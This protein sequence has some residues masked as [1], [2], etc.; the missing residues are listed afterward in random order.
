MESK[1]GIK[2]R[3]NLWRMGAGLALGAV[4]LFLALRFGQ[5]ED[6]I[7]K[8]KR[9]SRY[10]F[11]GFAPRIGKEAPTDERLAEWAKQSGLAK[12]ALQTLGPKSIPLLGHWLESTHS[13]Y[14]AK[15]A[16]VTRRLGIHWPALQ[17]D[18]RSIALGA[19][20]SVQCHAAEV[21]PALV[22][23][24]RS[25]SAGEQS[26]AAVLVNGILTCIPHEEQMAVADVLRAATEDYLSGL[27]QGAKAEPNMCVL[28]AKAYRLRP[29]P[30]REAAFRRIMRLN[31]TATSRRLF[32]QAESLLDPDGSLRNLAYL[33]EQE[34]GRIVSAAIFFWARPILAERVVPLLA[35]SLE[36]TNRGVLTRSAEALGEYGT[37]AVS[38]L[39]VL[40]NLVSDPNPRVSNAAKQAI[41]RIAAG[42]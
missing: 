21:V 37:N 10:L 39:P 19:L 35:K 23:M 16:E 3:K 13:K 42:R 31:D 12:E 8:G 1:A 17:A 34:E 40:S 25:A 6:P 11:D 29:P 36:S 4:I 28:V 41:G 9:L 18:R 5:P 33:E 22:S 14:R 26:M 24:T 38:A 32:E 2:L 27:E 7:Y 20:L 30:D 15:L